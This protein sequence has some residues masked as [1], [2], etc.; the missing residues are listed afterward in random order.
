MSRSIVMMLVLAL[1]L[2]TS[3]PASAQD[4]ATQKAGRLIQQG[5]FDDAIELMEPYARQNPDDGQPWAIL[6]SAYHGKGDYKTAVEMNQKAAKFT[7]YRATSLYNKACAQ[8]L[9]GHIEEAHRALT[10][11]MQAGFLDFD[12]IAQDA[13]LAQLRAKHDIPMPPAMDYESLTGR[14]GVKLGY[15]VLLPDDYDAGHTYRALVMFAPGPGERA[16]DWAQS[17]L[18]GESDDRRDWI[19]I[20]PIGPDRG[21]FTHPSHHALED[22]LKKLKS[23][24]RIEGD[25]FHLAGYGEGARVATT[26][27]QM[28]GAYFQSLTVFNAWHWSRWDDKD[29]KDDWGGMPVNLVVGAADE[30]GLPLNEK[31]ARLMKSAGANVTVSVL[32]GQ[33]HTLPQVRH[34]AVL[35]YL[36]RATSN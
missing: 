27:S 21:W 11:A 13:D 33:D 36:E 5:D 9:M 14:N 7:A 32:D 30:Y 6:A 16:A 1:S 8:A 34:G 31:T 24:Y 19:V 3:L 26:Y 2:L 22:L 25:L 29:L 23:D 20:Y 28:S 15:K 10:A 18:L 12:L 35:R 4:S 17:E